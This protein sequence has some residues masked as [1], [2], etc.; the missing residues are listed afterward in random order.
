MD[1]KIAV[2][3][4]ELIRLNTTALIK[5]LAF[6]MRRLFKVHLFEG[7]IYFIKILI[8]D[9]KHGESFVNKYYGRAAKYGHCELRNIVIQHGADY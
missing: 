5:F 9:K 6:L 1:N 2:T 4:T 3:G 8:P 7:G